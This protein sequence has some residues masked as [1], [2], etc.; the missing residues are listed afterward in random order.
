MPTI[1]LPE[2]YD[3]VAGYEPALQASGY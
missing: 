2:S 3:S 1:S